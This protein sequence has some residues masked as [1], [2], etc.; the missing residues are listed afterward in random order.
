MRNLCFLSGL[1]LREVPAG[2]PST[3]AKDGGSPAWRPVSRKVLVREAPGR[4]C[5]QSDETAKTTRAPRGIFCSGEVIAKS[6]VF[7]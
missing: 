1:S 3:S 2:H 7:F 4:V 6:Y 5:V